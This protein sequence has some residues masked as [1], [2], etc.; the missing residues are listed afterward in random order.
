MT[1]TLHHTPLPPLRRT[2]R[3]ALIGYLPAGYP[4]PATSATVLARLAQ[5]C[6]M[7]AVGMPTTSPSLVDGPALTRASRT[8][9]ALGTT[10]AVALRIAAAVR[11]AVN[12]P[13][14][15]VCSSTHIATAAP[16]IAEAAADA[17]LAGVLLRDLAPTSR[18]AIRW[19]A[20]ALEAR[21]A[22]SFV[23]D[24]DHE[25]A[26]A[27]RSA[28]VYLPATTEPALQV[29]RARARI[30]A[31]NT[32]S[33]API[34]VGGIT[35][36]NAASA[37]S[38]AIDALMISTQLVHALDTGGLRQLDRCAVTYASALQLPV[39]HQNHHVTRRQC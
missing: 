2:R 27:R 6:D 29:P 21:L 20:A 7:L 30:R 1:T 34:C 31:L 25:A 35:T 17:G 26:A 33:N 9:Q 22:T 19:H 3:A 39:P 23:A 37:L 38:P 14:T 16:A 36:P 8:A 18:G 24:P 11:S 15:L 13:L 5:H 28:W 32:A 10:P 4:T 12:T